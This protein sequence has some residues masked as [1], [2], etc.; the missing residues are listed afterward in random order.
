M[1]INSAT[2]MEQSTAPVHGGNVEQIARAYGLLPEEIVDFSANINPAGPPARVL[3]RLTELIANSA[4]LSRYPEANCHSLREALA[5]YVGLNSECIVVSNGSAALMD[6][7]VRALQ[8]RRCLLPVPA[9]SEY[10]RALAA[11]G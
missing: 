10:R 9:F 2:T 3:A 5:G 7:V 11:A 4:I 8:P 1:K 6:V